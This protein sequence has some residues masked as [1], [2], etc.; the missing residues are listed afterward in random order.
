MV[1]LKV[2]N[3]TNVPHAASSFAKKGALMR[4]LFGMNTQKANKLIYSL[5]QNITALQKQF[6]EKL[7]LL[8]HIEKQ[9]FQAL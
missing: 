3:D 6:S 8:K 7:M 4:I 9:R 2:F 5:L 1:K